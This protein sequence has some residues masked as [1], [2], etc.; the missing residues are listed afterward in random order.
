MD[1]RQAELVAFGAKMWRVDVTG[2]TQ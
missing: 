1:T 2:Y